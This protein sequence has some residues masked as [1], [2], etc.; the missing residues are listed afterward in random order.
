MVL[1]IYHGNLLTQIQFSYRHKRKGNFISY[2]T[3]VYSH[4]FSS[5]S[6]C[7]PASKFSAATEYVCLDIL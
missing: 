2:N 4:M 6:P 5:M 1:A 7:V 3:Y